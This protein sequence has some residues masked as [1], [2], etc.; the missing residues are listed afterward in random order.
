M[1]KVDQVELM[2]L[3]ACRI[4][5]CPVKSGTDG[6]WRHLKEENSVAH[7]VNATEEVTR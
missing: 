1:E 6:T 3:L 2:E 7:V 5:K 4:W